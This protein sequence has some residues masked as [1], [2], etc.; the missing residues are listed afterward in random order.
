MLLRNTE[1]NEQPS[2]ALVDEAENGMVVRMSKN[3][4]Q[5]EREGETIYIYDEVVFTV[6][7][8][9]ISGADDILWDFDEWWEFGEQPEE[10]EPTLEERIAAIE[11]FLIGG[12]L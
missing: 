7:K 1:S 5:E 12:E 9:R 10:S 3:V 2:A 6:P 8:G 4:R 11:D